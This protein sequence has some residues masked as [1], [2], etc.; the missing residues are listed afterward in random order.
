MIFGPE[1]LLPNIIDFRRFGPVAVTKPYKFIGLGA[2]DVT[3]PYKFVG[4]EPVDVASP[5]ELKGFRPM[6]VTK[7]C[8]FMLRNSA[9]G[10]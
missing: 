1:T 3:K 7:P 9:S 8:N 4:L 6:D 10:P 5:F 2:M